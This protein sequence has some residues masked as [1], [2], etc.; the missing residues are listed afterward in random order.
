MFNSVVAF[1]KRSGLS[2]VSS[3]AASQA[4]MEDASVAA[5]TKKPW[6]GNGEGCR[7]RW[8]WGA[9]F[10]G[11]EKRLPPLDTHY[12]NRLC[13]GESHSNTAAQEKGVT[14]LITTAK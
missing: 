5:D 2:P 1:S 4:A 3:G 8:G 6:T 7:W 9:E 12:S 14:Y 10:R 13:M 11:R